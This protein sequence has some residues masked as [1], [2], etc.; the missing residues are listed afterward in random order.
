ME[1]EGAEALPRSDSPI[2]ER[3]KASNLPVMRRMTGTGYLPV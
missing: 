2:S 1:E 3:T